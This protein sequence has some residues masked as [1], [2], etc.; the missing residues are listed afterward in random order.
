MHKRS[1]LSTAVK[2]LNVNFLF[3]TK[4]FFFLNRHDDKYNLVIVMRDA[5]GKSREAS[6]TKSFANFIDTNGTIVQP[7]VIN[8]ITKL[9][10]S[11]VSEKKDK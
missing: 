7:L 1:R 10:N 11:L 5:S 3:H 9:Y 2:S 6:I 4:T 8:E